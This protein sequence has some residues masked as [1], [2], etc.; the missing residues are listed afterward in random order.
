M[1]TTHSHL[2]SR[3]SGSV[4]V[5]RVV[6][7]ARQRRRRT[8]S[9]DSWRTSTAPAALSVALLTALATAVALG[10]REAVEL[11]LTFFVTG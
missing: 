4:A 5:R 10:L 7:P 9:G 2:V 1:T 8:R 3:P 11:A 6:R